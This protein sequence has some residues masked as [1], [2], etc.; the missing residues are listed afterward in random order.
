MICQPYKLFAG[1]KA[2]VVLLV[3]EG[4][5]AD[6]GG[7][8]LGVDG[9]D[10]RAVLGVELIPVGVA[11]QAGVGHDAHQI[12]GG[13]PLGI[14][15]RAERLPVLVYGKLGRAKIIL[16]FNKEIQKNL[17]ILLR[18]GLFKRI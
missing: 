1:G 5:D 7:A 10:L 13:A 4:E 3:S 15:V 12:G 16:S 2:V 6:L 11:V 17:S 9:D 14:E 8:V 18:L